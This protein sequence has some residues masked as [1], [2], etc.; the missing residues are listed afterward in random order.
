MC[1]FCARKKPQDGI[2]GNTKNTH[3]IKKKPHKT[4]FKVQGK[5]L[6]VFHA[7]LQDKTLSKNKCSGHNG[8]AG[9]F[10]EFFFF[11]S[12]LGDTTFFAERGATSCIL[13][14]ATV[15]SS[16]SSTRKKPCCVLCYVALT[17]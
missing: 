2:Y 12:Q 1:I 6:S 10:F 5:F 16:G 14:I 13:L 8:S 9:A 15:R 4:I 11:L 17:R 7:S 3:E